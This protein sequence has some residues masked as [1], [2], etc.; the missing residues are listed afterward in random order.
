MSDGVS[1]ARRARRALGR[2]K[3]RVRTKV[4][5][6]KA[7]RRTELLARVDSYRSPDPIPTLPNVRAAV[8]A[9]ER[10]RAGL[11][12]EWAQV[13]IGPHSWRK[14]LEEQDVDLV[15]LEIS[16]GTVYGWGDAAS[17]LAGLLEWG[18]KNGVPV[19]AWATSDTD[20]EVASGLIEGCRH[21]FLDSDK[22]L[23]KW[24]A[25]WPEAR[26]D[27]LQPA[28][29]P[30]LHNPLIGG[31]AWRRP[32]VAAAL[33][34]GTSP[35]EDALAEFDPSRLDVWPVD[36]RAGAALERS[37]LVNSAMYG[38]HLP[39]ANPVLS[40]YRVFV[41]LGASAAGPAWEVL[42]A[43]AAH[44]A[45][46]SEASALPRIPE[47]LHRYVTA[48]A[49]ANALKLDVA[50]RVW[51]DALRDREGLQLSREIYARHTFARRVDEITRAAGIPI[52][53]PEATVSAVVPTNR[54]HE[55]D[56]V[57]A[58]VGKQTHA[59]TGG[60]ELVLVLHGLDVNK[61]DVKA[62][63]Q[64]A[65]VSDLTVIEAESSLPLG[66]CMNLG[67]DASSGKFIAKMD[68][69]NF[70]GRNYLTDLVSAFE[71][72][73]A[74]IVGKWAHYVW[75][76]STGAVVLRAPKAEHRYDRLVQGG[77]MLFKADVVRT[78]R[79]GGHLPRGVDTDI[80]NRAQEAGIK[81]YSADRF[82]YVSI[83]GMD[84]HA[85]TWTIADT[86]LMNRAGTLVFYGDPR[87]HVDI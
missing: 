64:D 10:L 83:R 39:V 17:P 86:A 1:V 48:A 82:N 62:R 60:V 54:L 42:E 52:D 11:A 13:D 59:A 53:R 23:E 25:R 7:S 56:N 22:S 4:L 5:G 24:R 12:W 79:F 69:D 57:L 76:Q 67:V 70:Y 43:G 28:A 36:A 72:T 49:D 46:V 85:H 87:E 20:P 35:M 32:Q 8:A 27:V 21:I 30:R 81:T 61:A 68:D 3:R 65:G 47:D 14:I 41:E 34:F 78:L 71:Y 26:L 9:G 18:R 66:A 44:T 73:D 38:R 40:R 80:L 2:V 16:G 19:L 75:L 55:L 63:A 45:V 77:S 58:N 50:A 15:L 74:G 29:Q 84:R 31:T 6:H 51:Q 33:H 37:S